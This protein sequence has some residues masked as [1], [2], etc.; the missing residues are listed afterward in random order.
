M[1]DL[2]E[3]VNQQFR[4]GRLDESDN[5]NPEA[6]VDAFDY[7]NCSKKSKQKQ[8]KKMSKS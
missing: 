8:Q 1:N 3:F 4:E 2:N 5:E 7:V 6:D